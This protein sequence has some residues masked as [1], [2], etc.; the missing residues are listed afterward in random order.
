MNDLIKM[1][2]KIATISYVIFF[3]F[4]SSCASH[5]KVAYLQDIKSNYTMD[6][7]LQKN[8]VVQSG[9]WI[10]IVVNSKD[11]ALHGSQSRLP[12][13]GEVLAVG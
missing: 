4:L 7:Q 5:K 1:K 3:V 13:H 10:S 8:A 11:D 6:I 9:D 12:G 2:N